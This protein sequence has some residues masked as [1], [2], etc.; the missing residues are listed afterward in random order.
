[1]FELFQYQLSFARGGVFSLRMAA[2]GPILIVEPHQ[3]VTGDVTRA[4]SEEFERPV[5]RSRLVNFLW[6]ILPH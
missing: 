1:M 5:Y 2:L 6:R 4:L 3:Y